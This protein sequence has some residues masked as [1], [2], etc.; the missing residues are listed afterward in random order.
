MKAPISRK[1]CGVSR[2][3][4]RHAYKDDCEPAC[5]RARRVLKATRRETRGEAPHPLRGDEQG[6]H[7]LPGGAGAARLRPFTPIASIAFRLEVLEEEVASGSE[8]RRLSQHR[9][10]GTLDTSRGCAAEGRAI[11]VPIAHLSNFHFNSVGALS[12]GNTLAQVAALLWQP[13]EGHRHDEDPVS[14]RPGVRGRRE[15]GAVHVFTRD[16]RSE[17]PRPRSH[18]HHQGCDLVPA[19]RW[20]QG[21]RHHGPV[22]EGDLAADGTFDYAGSRS[23]P[24]APP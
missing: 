19:G 14:A 2:K 4:A 21:H 11:I 12:T 23:M 5:R 7:V 18:Q 17:Q 16:G 15:R 1:R 8:C 3:F 22:F 20:W 10:D 9:P 24:A 13:Q 6:V